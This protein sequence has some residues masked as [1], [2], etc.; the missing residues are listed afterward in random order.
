MEI[1][2]DILLAGKAMSWGTGRDAGT[3]YD[4]RMKVLEGSSTPQNRLILCR[5]DP[6]LGARRQEYVDLAQQQLDKAYQRAHAHAPKSKASGANGRIVAG[7]L[8]LL[9]SFFLGVA[10]AALAFRR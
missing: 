7:S 10:V 3:F 8:P 9:G 4:V 6:S 2:M 1:V 5:A